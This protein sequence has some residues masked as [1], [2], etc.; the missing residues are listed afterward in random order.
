MKHTNV[1]MRGGGRLHAFTLVELLVVIAIIGI[2]IALLL[3]AVQAAR[4]A[5]RRMQC[6]NN[7]KQLSLATH[8]FHDAHKRYPSSGWDQF[9][10]SYRNDA[11]CNGVRMHG[12]DVY[13]FFACLLPFFEQTASYD[14]LHAQLTLAAQ[15]G[16]NDYTYTPEPWRD[17]PGTKNNGAGGTVPDPFGQPQSVFRCPSDGQRLG[18]PACNYKVSQGDATAAYDWPTVRGFAFRRFG[19]QQ[20]D[21]PPGKVP[22]SDNGIIS[23]SSVSD[24]LSNTLIFSESCVGKGGSD[25]GVKTGIVELGGSWRNTRS[26]P[27]ECNDWRGANNSY[28]PGAEAYHGGKGWSWGDARSY[29]T[30]FVTMSPPNAPSCSHGDV[31]AWSDN[32]ASS[33][34]TGGVNIGMCDGSVQFVS[35]TINC[36]NQN[37]HNGGDDLHPSGD[38]YRYGGPSTF[39]VWG[40]LGSRAGGDSV[41]SF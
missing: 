19:W 11:V 24:G 4:E 30:L 9:W 26:A 31:W 15:Y 25:T 35:D 5:A 32:N 20:D 40:A 34:H 6:T 17:T 37:V 10:M 1:K 36:G 13:S 2:L 29:R 38:C 7:L 33:Y 23:F 27:G 16:D 8:T 14:S 28:K 18:N 41:G 12:I 22:Y 39:G 3:P 21:N